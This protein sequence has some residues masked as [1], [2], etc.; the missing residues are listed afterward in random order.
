MDQALRIED[1]D[2]ALRIGDMAQALRIGDAAT[3]S[4]VTRDTIRFY[5]RAGL[6]NAPARTSAR[7]RTYDGKTLKRIRLVRQLQNCGLTISDIKEILFLDGAD[8]PVA[9]K[10][11][12]E[13]LRRR[14]IFLEE[15]ISSMEVCR[16]RLIDVLREVAAARSA[17]YGV[18]DKLPDEDLPALFRFGRRRKDA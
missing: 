11:L 18:L 6:L 17:G 15:R 16:E 2:Q 13:I 8:R 10:R 9:S 5:E 14:L 12:I 7:H 3:R 1:M 4:G